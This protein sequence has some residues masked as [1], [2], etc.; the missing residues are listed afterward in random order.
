M[1]RPE[2][3]QLLLFD[4]HSTS[5]LIKID[6]RSSSEV[7]IVG[8]GQEFQG[9]IKHYAHAILYQMPKKRQ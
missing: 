3:H 5:L 7:F 6:L 2:V 9:Y 4:H 8:I 1:Y